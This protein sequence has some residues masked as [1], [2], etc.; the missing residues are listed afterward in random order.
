MNTIDLVLLLPLALAV[1]AGFRKGFIIEIASLLAFVLAIIACLKLTHKLMELAEPYTG[2][3]KWL[4][5]ICYL[6]VF[7][8]VYILVLWIGKI[9]E[10]VIKI[11]QLGALNRALGI[12]FSLLKMCIMIS[13]FFWLAD[14]IHLIPKSTENQSYIYKALHGF[15]TGFIGWLSDYLPWVKGEIDQIE[16]FFGNLAK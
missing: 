11:I 14:M 7:V 5:F 16:A 13:L 3:S 12:L 4:P 6:L 1:I 2:H 9:L 8:L 15:A 10:K